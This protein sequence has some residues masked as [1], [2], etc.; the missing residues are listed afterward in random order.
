MSLMTFYR[1]VPER[2]LIILDE[3]YF[4]YAQGQ[5]PL[6]RLHALSL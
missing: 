2:V 1:H 4:E 6:S 5:S 3:A